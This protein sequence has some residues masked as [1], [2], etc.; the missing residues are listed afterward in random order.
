MTAATPRRAGRPGTRSRDYRAEYE[1]RK[2]RAADE[3]STVAQQ[4]VSRAAALG[5][6]P[7][8][9]VGHPRAG[10]RS[11]R[12]LHGEQNW[13]V[14][15]FAEPR[16]VVTVQVSRADAVRA[17]RYNRL[18]RD[19]R[20]GRMTPDDFQRRASRMKPIATHRVVSDPKKALA[21]AILTEPDEYVFDSPRAGGRTRRR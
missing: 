13:T 18:V 14:T 12:A 10:E 21:L 7:T 8:Q 15:I 2:V 17:G 3:G 19:L 4:R 9:A 5:L 6:S 11:A 1:R 16:D 20:E